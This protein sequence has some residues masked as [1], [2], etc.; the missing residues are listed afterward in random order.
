MNEMRIQD[1]LIRELPSRPGSNWWLPV[2]IAAL[3]LLGV[4]TVICTINRIVELASG[5]PKMNYR[6][7]LSLLPSIVH[8]LFIT[9]MIGHAVTI[10]MGSW[11]RIPLSEGAETSIGPSVPQL[12]VKRIEDEYFPESSPLSKR[13]RQKEVTLTEK[14]GEEIRVSYLDSIRYHGYRLQLD[15]VKQ[16]PGSAHMERHAQVVDDTETCN[17]SETY[18][19]R[20]KTREKSQTVYLL[21]ISDPGL[22]V[23]L[24]A[25]TLILVIMTWYFVEVPRK[26]NGA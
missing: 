15:M 3:A 10:T 12:S 23:I 17:K 20:E 26:R 22:P 25:F 21:A 4:N 14:N 16:K 1:W 7:I 8:M 13:I 11:T 19:S 5:A 24:T 6:F 18:R 9:A 2:Q